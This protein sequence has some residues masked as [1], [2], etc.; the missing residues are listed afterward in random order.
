MLTYFILLQS[1]I[2]TQEE[3]N[4]VCW[5]ADQDGFVSQEAFLGAKF[6]FEDKEA[7]TDLYYHEPFERKRFIKESLFRANE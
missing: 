4:V 3:A 5:A 7:S 6:W 2:P 1:R